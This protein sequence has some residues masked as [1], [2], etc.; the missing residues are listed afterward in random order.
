MVEEEEEEEEK[1]ADGGREEA[2]LVRSW[3]FHDGY[4][5]MDG[6]VGRRIC[7]PR[8]KGPFRGRVQK[9]VARGLD[10]APCAPFLISN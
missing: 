3:G 8:C 7:P 1:A 5:W 4:G 10:V 9:G 2:G 6:W